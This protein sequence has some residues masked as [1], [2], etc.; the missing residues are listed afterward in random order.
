MSLSSPNPPD[1]HIKFPPHH[2]P[3]QPTPP[4][5]S[6]PTPIN[7]DGSLYSFSLTPPSEHSKTKKKKMKQ[8]ICGVR[9]HSI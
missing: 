5:Y 7:I 6:P 4:P 3:P 8:S 9:N 1:P 2:K